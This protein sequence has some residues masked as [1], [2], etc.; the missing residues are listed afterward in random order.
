LTENDRSN[1]CVHRARVAGRRTQ[2]PV[3]ETLGWL[4]ACLTTASFVPQVLLALR[5]RDLSGLSIRMYVTLCA[6]LALWLAYGIC[7]PSTPVIA[8]N[9]VTLTL[10]ATILA[11]A[12][13][14]RRA[15][16]R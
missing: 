12:I 8:A 2:R 11:L 9:A 7:K 3:V 10:A 6:G 16:R 4:A 1:L 15:S 5:T 13:R 14:H